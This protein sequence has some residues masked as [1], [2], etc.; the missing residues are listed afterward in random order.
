MRASD[1]TRLSRLYHTGIEP[2]KEPSASFVGG[3][4]YTIEDVNFSQLG[5][6]K[7]LY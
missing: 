6:R 7:L 5:L 1:F 2:Y 3:R 4:K